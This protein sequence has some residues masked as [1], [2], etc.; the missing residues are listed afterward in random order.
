[1]TPTASLVRNRRPGQ[2]PGEEAPRPARV[3]ALAPPGALLKRLLIGFWAMYFTLVAVTNA[4]DLL[5]ELGALH[6]RFLNSGNFAYMSS[7]VQVYDVGATPTKLLLAGAL[8]VE[9]VGA[10]LCWRALLRPSTRRALQAVCWS[11]LVWIAFV[12]MTELFVAYTSESPFRELLMLA[13][14]TGL[15]IALVPDDAGGRPPAG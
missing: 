3:P 15:V 1:M 13:I 4:V 14:G 8:A 11:A 7:I 6:W 2:L 9:A 5:G 10:L 12:F